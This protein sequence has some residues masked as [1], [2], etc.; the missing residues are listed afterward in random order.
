MLRPRQETRHRNR[1]EIEHLR[2]GQF[3]F[4]EAIQPKYLFIYGLST[5]TSPTLV[6]QNYNIIAVSGNDLR[7]HFSLPFSRL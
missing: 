5:A 1:I 7:V 3:P 2:A 4:P 6:P